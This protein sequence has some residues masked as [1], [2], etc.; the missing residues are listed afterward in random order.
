MEVIVAPMPE[1]LPMELSIKY[2]KSG[3]SSYMLSRGGQITDSSKDYN[4]TNDCNKLS[5]RTL[6]KSV[7]AQKRIL[8]AEVK[9]DARYSL[10]PSIAAYL[11]G[12]VVIVFPEVGPGPD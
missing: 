8:T 1:A 10:K 9:W 6:L 5:N 12:H 11:E 2:N 7:L 3:Y 4:Q